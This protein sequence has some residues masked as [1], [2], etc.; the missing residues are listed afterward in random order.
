MYIRIDKLDGSRQPL[1]LEELRGRLA[2]HYSLV[3]EEVGRI[4]Q[5]A[6]VSDDFAWYIKEFVPGLRG[7]AAQNALAQ[8][9]EQEPES[10]TVNYGQRF[11][12]ITPDGMEHF[13][14]FGAEV[15]AREMTAD[16]AMYQ[17]LKSEGVED[18][19]R[20]EELEPDT[21]GAL[22]DLVS[23]A[24][25]FTRTLLSGE[26]VK[27]EAEAVRKIAE[28]LQPGLQDKLGHAST[29]I[30]KL[31]DRARTTPRLLELRRRREALLYDRLCVELTALLLGYDLKM[32][33]GTHFYSREEWAKRGEEFGQ[34]SI[35]TMTFDGNLLHDM[36]NDL[37]AG[38]ELISDLDRLLSGFGY[39]YEMGTSWSLSL[40]PNQA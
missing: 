39:G 10:H 12:V 15:C 22:C 11:F 35:L 21:L 8:A 5:G 28:Y 33:Q 20:P 25:Y 4:D 19:Q 29:V 24:D 23:A 27:L 18:L 38:S 37:E 1:S 26:F 9:A 13:T 30:G 2:K 40:Y 14:D 17:V 16:E 36:L 31:K 3:D 6:T 32:V 34:D 7:T